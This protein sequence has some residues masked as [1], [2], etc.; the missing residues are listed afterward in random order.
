MVNGQIPL[1]AANDL[2]QM[3]PHAMREQVFPQACLQ[4]IQDDVV[5]II[6]LK[7]FA[8]GKIITTIEFLLS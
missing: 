4:A 1:I 2:W 6:D 3:R 8:V 7:G 5:N